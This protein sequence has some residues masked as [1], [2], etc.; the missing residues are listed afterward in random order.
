MTKL[1]R[2][3]TLKKIKTLKK[4]KTNVRRKNA[5]NRKTQKGGLYFSTG[6]LKNLKENIRDGHTLYIPGLYIPDIINGSLHIDDIP[7]S[8]P[9]IHSI[10]D[11]VY[12]FKATKEVVH[13]WG[14]GGNDKERTMQLV[15]TDNN[16]NKKHFYLITYE[17]DKIHYVYEIQCKNLENLENIW[18]NIND[19]NNESVI[20]KTIDNKNIKLKNFKENVEN[21]HKIINQLVTLMKEV[22]K[23]LIIKQKQNDR[24]EAADARKM[25]KYSRSQYYS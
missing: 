17:K 5:S 3:N 13:K 19:I 22:K 18:S 24:K 14:W 9:D 12:I 10:P 7:D 4:R 16:N 6:Q 23:Q 15:Y 1:T 20:I 8:I 21:K 25:A 2:R 11:S